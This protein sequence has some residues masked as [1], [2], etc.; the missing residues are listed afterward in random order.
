MAEVGLLSK[1]MAKSPIP[2]C[3]GCM[4]TAM[5]KNPCRSKGNNTGG[6]VERITKITR[7]R[8][9]VFV[10]VLESSQ[11]G[12]IAHMKGRPT[13]KRY[14][15][16][17]VFV[18]HFLDLKYIHCMSKITSE[19]TLYTKK[20]FERHADVFNVRVEHYHC[21]NGQFAENVFIQHCKEMGQGITYCGVNAHF[22]NGSGEKDTRDLQTMAQKMIIHEKG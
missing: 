4:F 17:T 5:T 19:E 3:A 12:F 14:R 21:D 13:K 8:Q 9:C 6:H 18:D 22:Q 20:S 2:K 11:V 1:N 15:Y 10:N 16:E 7:P